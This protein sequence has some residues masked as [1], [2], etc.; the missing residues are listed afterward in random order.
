[1][2]FPIEDLITEVKANERMFPY[3]KSVVIKIAKKY[4]EHEKQIIEKLGDSIMNLKVQN[5]RLGD[6]AI[7]TD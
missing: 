3:D 5:S 1:M 6:K 7:K 4:L 2:R